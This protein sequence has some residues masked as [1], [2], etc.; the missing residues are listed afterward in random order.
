LILELSSIYLWV[1]KGFYIGS[2]LAGLIILSGGFMVLHT[3]GHCG[4]SSNPKT[5]TFWF[6]F[7]S[8]YIFGFP[9]K[10]WDIHHNYAHHCYTNI[11]RKDPDVSNALSVIRKNES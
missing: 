11:H 9:Y 7:Y 4:L 2:I 5:N 10:I 8:N 6:N 3:A 1:F